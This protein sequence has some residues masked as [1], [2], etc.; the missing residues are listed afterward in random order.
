MNFWED[1]KKLVL[2]HRSMPQ[3][4]IKQPINVMLTPQFYTLKK[5]ILPIKFAFQA[6]RI[7]ASLFEGMLPE[8]RSYEYFVFKEGEY[9][10]FIAYSLEEITEFFKSKGLSPEF[11]SKLFF[12]QQS[13]SSFAQPYLISDNEVLAVLNDTVVVMPKS[14]VEDEAVETT[15]E[16]PNPKR[17]IAVQS[18]YASVLSLKEA[19]GFAAIFVLFAALFIVEGVRYGGDTESGRQE[20]ESLIEENPSLSSQYTRDNI[21]T[22]YRKIDEAE[23]KKRDAVKTLIGLTYKGVELKTIHIDD[24]GFRAEYAVKEDKTIKQMESEAKKAKFTVQKA[25]DGINVE[26]KL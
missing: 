12:V 1:N 16:I 20:L 15:L 17:G 4:E 25:T 18:A 21:V 10:V 6:K 23:R 26:G 8:G 7:A 24:K 2:I 3:M 22:K 14:T 19:L 11:I 13:A 9:W 5:E